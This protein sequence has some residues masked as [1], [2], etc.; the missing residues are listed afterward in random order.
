MLAAARAERDAG[1][2][3]NSFTAYRLAIGQWLRETWLEKSGKSNS[4]ITNPKELAAKLR[5]AGS[6]DAWTHGVLQA[7]EHRPCPVDWV[8]IDMLAAVVDAV[9]LERDRETAQ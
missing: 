4:P 6:I 9:T 5:S 2:L 7:V 1:Q 8:H 3:E